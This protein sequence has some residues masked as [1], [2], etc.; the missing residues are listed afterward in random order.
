MSKTLHDISFADLLPSSITGDPSVRA[1]AMAMDS[2]L[3]SMG[4]AVEKICIYS[5]FDE[6]EEPL[7]THLAWQFKLDFWD[8]SL[9]VETKRSLVRNAYAW[10]R[11]K[12]TPSAVEELVSIVFGQGD[13]LEWFEYDGEPYHFKIITNAK[14]AIDIDLFFKAIEKIK[15]LSTVLDAIV[16]NRTLDLGLHCSAANRMHTGHAITH[17]TAKECETV[18]LATAAR[19]RSTIK[20]PITADQKRNEIQGACAVGVRTAGTIRAFIEPVHHVQK[21]VEAMQSGISIK[22]TITTFITKE[23]S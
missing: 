9:P 8:A 11:R 2:E 21:E 1:A 10:H 22:T 19:T 18:S 7:L 4:S 6:I 20:T 13:V 15:R 5:R 14:N 12:G 3:K 23:S 16:I 17:E